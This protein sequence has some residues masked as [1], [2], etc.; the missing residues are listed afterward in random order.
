[1]KIAIECSVVFLLLLAGTAEA[2]EWA[3]A[4]REGECAPLSVLEKK[5]PEFR[6]IESPDQLVQ[7][8]RSAGQKVEIK[9]HNAGSRPAVEVRVPAR[10]LYV[11]F[12]KKEMCGK[13]GPSPGDKSSKVKAR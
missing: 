9:E 6:G 1:M 3:L 13:A 10:N 4:G 12:V 8:M 11:M 2:A 5:G 7:K